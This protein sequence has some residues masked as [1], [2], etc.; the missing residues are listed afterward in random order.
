MVTSKRF[1]LQIKAKTMQNSLET[2]FVG[3][4][5]PQRRRLKSPVTIIIGIKSTNGIVIA[6]D[7]RTIDPSGYVNDYAQKLHTIHFQDGNSA[8]IGEAGNAEFSSRAVEMIT[9][10][11]SQQKFGDYRTVATC[12]ENAISDLKQKIREQYKGTAEEL[13]K[14]F[15]AYNFELMIAHYWN[16]RPYIF[17]LNFATGMATKKDREYCA[18]GCGWILADFIIS[19]LDV[20]NFDSGQGMWTAIYAV[21][22]I[23][24]L[25]SRCGGR[26][27]CGVITNNPSG[28][29][30]AECGV[31]NDATMQEAINEALSF[32]EDVKSQWKNVARHRIAQL[33]ERRKAQI[34]AKSH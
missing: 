29:S 19:R 15:E 3:C 11:A 31:D 14:H 7:S 20:S 9:S 2:G 33:V 16:T 6:C 13:Q 26:T 24:K 34:K 22:E 25:D 21:E 32:S 23:K 8:I 28:L 10:S 5:T 18:I 4:K 30:I 27:R 17:T 1:P 12:A